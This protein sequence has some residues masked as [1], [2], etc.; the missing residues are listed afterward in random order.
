MRVSD[1]LPGLIDTAILDN[2]PN[3]SGDGDNGLRPQPDA[4][5]EGPFRLMPPESVAECA[6]K[7]YHDEG[8]TLHWYVPEEIGMIDKAKAAGAE[9]VRDQIAQTIP[10]RFPGD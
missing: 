9:A 1:V 3:H 2:T 8:G 5:T 4:P 6:F 10:A 7:A